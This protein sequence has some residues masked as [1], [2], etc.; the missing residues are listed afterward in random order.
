[1]EPNPDFKTIM[2]L[3]TVALG[4]SATIE[5]ILEGLK[6]LMKKWLLREDSPF[7]Q[8]ADRVEMVLTELS[9]DKL[10]SVLD[11]KV[12]EI[13]EIHV[14]L[15]EAPDA[16]KAALQQKA[17]QIEEEA[18]KL[19]ERV[20][21][22]LQDNI[23]NANG[24]LSKKQKEQLQRKQ[25]KLQ[26]RIREGKLL[27]DSEFDE[28]VSVATV[29]VDPIAPRDPE[30]TARIFWLQIIG[31]VS[32]VFV[33]YFSEFGMF[34]FLLTNVNLADVAD[35][36]LTG[37]LI[38][39]GA[40]PIH[41]LIKFITERKVTEMKV[42][43]ESSVE[44][45][46]EKEKAAPAVVTKP[47]VPVAEVDVPY[48]GGVNRESLEHIHLRN[49]NPD[50]IIY[51]HT[52][53]HSDST[54]ADVVKVIEDKGW[55]TGYNCVIV[56]DGNIHPFCRWDRYGNHAK[57]Y[58]RRSLGI[59]LNGNFEPNP[60]ISFANVNGTL[61]ILRPT[62]AQLFS[63]CKVVALWC[64]LYN[65]PVDFD[66]SVIPHKQIANKACPGS[67]FPYDKFK[68]LVDTIYT[69]WSKKDS[70]AQDELALYAQKQYLFV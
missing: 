20:Q 12:E 48:R 59:A 52:A 68:T 60:E 32:G 2:L 54:F 6:G 4:L 9:F 13:S 67:N 35:W 58:N 42:S 29:F 16:E 36:T 23:E 28:Q 31:V 62:D 18:L 5:R 70:K 25:M 24:Q 61:G 47:E 10:N 22:L 39:G 30:K 21:G 46:E 19:Y 33:C 17:K 57:G 43:T 3:L 44:T 37:I 38:G 8:E 51:H 63:L 55:S 27:L 53:M 11:D 1:M 65:I 15:A 69:Q 7:A 34:D 49:A 50:L 66:N 56:K 26:S 41:T 40:Q 45:E 14:E 64:H